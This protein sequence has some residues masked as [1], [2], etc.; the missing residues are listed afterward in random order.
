[1]ASTTNELQQ[2]RISVSEIDYIP[3]Q[4]KGGLIGFVC[5][6]LNASFRLG[7]IAVY[8]R[9]DGSGIRLVFP[10]KKLATGATVDSARP[11]S[12]EVGEAVTKA[13]ADHISM[14]H[15]KLAVTE[16]ARKTRIG[17]DENGRL[18]QDLA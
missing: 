8:Q 2:S 16:E 3:V 4:P 11:L 12:R 14:L 6:T 5:F 10:A 9:L 15:E 17:G 7:N 13:V 18:A 1:M